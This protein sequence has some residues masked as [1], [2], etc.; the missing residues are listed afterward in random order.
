MLTLALFQNISR[1]HHGI[2]LYFHDYTVQDR[3]SEKL[4]KSREFL[5][6]LNRI[7]E[8]CQTLKDF[9]LRLTLKC[10]N[11]LFPETIV[12][13]SEKNIFHVTLSPNSSSAHLFSVRERMFSTGGVL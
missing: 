1:L 9:L 7:S 13:I 11:I 12:T 2:I 6:H 10:P 8:P 4:K 5:A 3:L